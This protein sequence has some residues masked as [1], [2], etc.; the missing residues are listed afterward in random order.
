[1]DKKYW[2]RLIHTISQNN[3]ILM[4]GPDVSTEI[5]ENKDVPCTEILAQELA[6]TIQSENNSWNI[7]LNP[8][9][10]FQISQYYLMIE[11]REWLE[12][13]IKDF[14]IQ[15]EKQTCA[16]LENLAALPF[17]FTIVTTPDQM[18]ENALKKANKN[19]I[20]EFFNYYGTNKDQVEMGTTEK[21]LIYQIFGSVEKPSSLVT[22]EDNLF[23]FFEELVSKKR[24]IPAN[25]DCEI[26]SKNKSFLFLGFGFKHWYLRLLLHALQIKNKKVNKSFAFEKINRISKNSINEFHRTIILLQNSDYRIQF[27]NEDLNLFV[28]QLRE[29]YEESC[30]DS[31][32]GSPCLEPVENQEDTPAPIVFI[33][34]ANEDKQMAMEIYDKLKIAHFEPWVDQKKLRGGDQ[35]DNLIKQ[36]INKEI[37]YFIV[38]QSISLFNKFEGYVNKEIKIARERQS[39]FQVNFKFIIPIIIEDMDHSYL[40]E[41]LSEYQSFDYTKQNIDGL[42]RDIT[43]DFKRRIQKKMIIASARKSHE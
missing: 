26:K 10:L 8:D 13:T 19:P 24:K 3:C 11:D 2:K 37:D 34:H 7:P 21:P 6:E 32:G 17:Y 31:V 25:I 22:T 28:S 39:G 12:T 5:F 38:L 16:L 9:N 23:Q 20:V 36:T 27:F 42:I 15:R 40:R 35:W 18:F 4:L 30:K 41:D 29:K 33:C 1:M 14:Y 43:K